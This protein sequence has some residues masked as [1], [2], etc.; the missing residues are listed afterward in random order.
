MGVLESPEVTFS[1]TSH[2]VSVREP[3][4]DLPHAPHQ[5]WFRSTCPQT[6]GCREPDEAS[7][8]VW[9]ST[10]SHTRK[11]GPHTA[12]QLWAP[13]P[14][15]SWAPWKG[16]RPVHGGAVAAS[17]QHGSSRARTELAASSPRDSSA[18]KLPPRP[19]RHGRSRQGGRGTRWLPA[20][21]PSR[22]IWENS[23]CPGQRGS[24]DPPPPSAPPRS[25]VST[26]RSTSTSK[27]RSA[28]S[29]PSGPVCGT[30]GP[31]PDAAQPR[32]LLT[33]DSSTGAS[34]PSD[35]RDRLQTALTPS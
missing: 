21:T 12:A 9:A 1:P 19:H 20:A 13:R 17:G 26:G 22:G 29:G 4:Q 8:A 25:S 24:Q 35:L 5:F 6:C 31:G 3:A 10:P 11:R 34:F 18:G 27:T 14:S 7:E 28:A 16:G 15:P 2:H 32:L 33:A 23:S 30:R